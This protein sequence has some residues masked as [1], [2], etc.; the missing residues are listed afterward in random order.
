MGFY[1]CETS[2]G[3]DFDFDLNF[4]S[5]FIEKKNKCEKFDR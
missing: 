2:S 3:F 5:K 1:L 4:Y